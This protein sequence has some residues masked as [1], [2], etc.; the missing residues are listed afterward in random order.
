MILQSDFL[1][2]KENITGI[3]L[4]YSIKTQFSWFKRFLPDART[5]GVIYNQEENQ[6]MINET[7]LWADKLGLTLRAEKVSSPREIPVA[8]KN[9]SKA[10][11]FSWVFPTK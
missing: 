10:L 8:L 2:N 4:E 7:Q 3:F 1:K 9:L 5:I 6:A 11:M